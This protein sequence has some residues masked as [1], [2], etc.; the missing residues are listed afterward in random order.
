MKRT[1]KV[2]SIMLSV[3]MLMQ[4]MTGAVFAASKLPTDLHWG[5]VENGE[6]PTTLYF[7]VGGNA[8][9]ASY[10]MSLY[11]NG[12]LADAYLTEM[13]SSDALEECDNDFADA[14]I[15]NG[16][17]RYSVK[18]GVLAKS[19]DEYDEYEDDA[20]IPVIEETQMS[21]SFNYIAPANK[22][23]SCTDEFED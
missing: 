22:Q 16:S 15:K 1:S 9:S 14:I 2:I 6:A 17:G 7:T 20:D 13:E 10:K 23:I 21:D 19:I 4:M 8:T 18:I 5:N 12:I 3:F 11:K